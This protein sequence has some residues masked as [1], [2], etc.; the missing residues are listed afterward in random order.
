MPAGVDEEEALR[1][2]MKASELQGCRACRG[3]SCHSPHARMYG[4]GGGGHARYRGLKCDPMQRKVVV[5]SIACACSGRFFT[6]IVLHNGDKPITHE[7]C[8]LDAQGDTN[9]AVLSSI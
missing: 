3:V 8:V 1:L 9:S 2:A 6:G 5:G 7:I 4:R